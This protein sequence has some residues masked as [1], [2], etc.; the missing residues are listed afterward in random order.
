M[1]RKQN[2]EM[3]GFDH[4][5]V[6]NGYSAHPKID[7]ETKQVYN[8]GMGATPKELYIYKHSS[9]MKLL[10]TNNITLRDYQIIHDCTLAGKYVVVLEC[11]ISFDLPSF[12]LSKPTLNCM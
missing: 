12:V 9:D 10:L 2:L 7:P 11:P 6:K 5:G 1:I 8:I 4:F 3:I